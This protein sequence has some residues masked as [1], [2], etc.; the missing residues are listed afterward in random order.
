[1][2]DHLDLVIAGVGGQGNI[3]LSRIVGETAL[4]AGTDVR[5][6]EAF[7]AAQRGGAVLSHVR[8]G[9]SHSPVIPLGR[10][11]ALLALEPGEAL[12]QSRFLRQ[13]GLA[14][15]NTKPIMPVEVLAGRATYP[16]I[17]KIKELMTRLT[18]NLFMTDA[19]KLAEQAGNA[20]TANIVMLGAL[21]G[22]KI[23]PFQ[24][25]ALEESISI[26]VPKK[27]IDANLKAFELGRAS[28]SSNMQMA[29]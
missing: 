20:M 18:S 21:D 5:I 3:L 11:N 28:V 1:V 12:R 9:K 15:V 2:K 23:L 24:P 17:D 8:L 26:M 25:H 10:A 22:C 13:D 4:R 6:S 27:M 16:P 14:V 7:G 29:N 19:A